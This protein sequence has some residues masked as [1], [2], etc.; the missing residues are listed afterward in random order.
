M[1]DQTP[2][3]PPHHDD[4]G[5]IVAYYYG[6][7]RH[8]HA[9]KKITPKSGYATTHCGMAGHYRGYYGD[10]MRK[11]SDAV[12]C[13]SCLRSLAAARTQTPAKNEDG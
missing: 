11:T 5:T 12:T 9:A 2:N 4:T 8:I 10:T 7:G 1:T 13:R 3:S 6:H